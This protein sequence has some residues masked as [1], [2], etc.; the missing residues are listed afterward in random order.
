MPDSPEDRKFH[1]VLTG[2]ITELVPGPGNSPDVEKPFAN[3]LIEF[4]DSSYV[5]VAVIEQIWGQMHEH[6]TQLGPERIKFWLEQGGSG[7]ESKVAL[8]GKFTNKPEKFP[9]E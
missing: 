2:V 6:L 8:M 4:H 7:P 9:A 5:D 3:E 1:I